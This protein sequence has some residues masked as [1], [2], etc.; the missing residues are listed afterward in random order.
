MKG[1]GGFW[2]QK[3]FRFQI[4]MKKIILQP[5]IEVIFPNMKLKGQ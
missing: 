1:G 4:L 5:Q 3:F 2:V